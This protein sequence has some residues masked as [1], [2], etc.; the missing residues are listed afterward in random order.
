VVFTTPTHEQGSDDV[1]TNPRASI[2]SRDRSN[3]GARLPRIH[4]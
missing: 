2:Q 4:R 1:V 3:A